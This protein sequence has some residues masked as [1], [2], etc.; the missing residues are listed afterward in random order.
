MLRGPPNLHGPPLLI[1]V[2]G[3]EDRL[4]PT[5]ACSQFSSLGRFRCVLGG[6]MWA[7]VPL[8]SV[9]SPGVLL[10][11]GQSRAWAAFFQVLPSLCLR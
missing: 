4:P 11:P 9:E 10:R 2:P 8:S 6:S 3:Q 7:P 5:L 1:L